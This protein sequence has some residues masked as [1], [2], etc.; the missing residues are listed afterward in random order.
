MGTKHI[1]GSLRTEMIAMRLSG[2][3][4]REIAAEAG[5]TKKQVD[6]FFERQNKKA[7]MAEADYIP[8]RKS[9]PRK[10]ALTPEARI[11][12]L[13]R[14]VALLRSFLHAAGRM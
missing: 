11:K 7:R 6:K 8:K 4:H 9:R 1:P 12:E 14:E 3:T 10:T 5:Y 2:H 13:E